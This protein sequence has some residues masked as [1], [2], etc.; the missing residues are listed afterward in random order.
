MANFITQLKRSGYFDN[1]EIKDATETDLVKSA[2]T[3][4]F[5]MTAADSGVPAPRSVRPSLSP[6]AA[7]LLR[8][9]QRR[10]GANMATA[11][12]NGPGPCRLFSMLRWRW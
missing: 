8:S 3:F 10:G 9:R 1:V 11:F 12:R 6:R 5:S 4:G 7:K 2:Q